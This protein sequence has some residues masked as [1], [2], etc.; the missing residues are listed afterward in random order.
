MFVVSFMIIS[1]L[2][3]CAGHPVDTQSTTEAET[4]GEASTTEAETT[5][6]ISDT[7]ETSQRTV[8]LNTET[9][10]E[11]PYGTEKYVME[12]DEYGR[13]TSSKTYSG[14]AEMSATYF[15]YD[16]KGYCNS[17]KITSSSGTEMRDEWTNDA[18]GNIL[19]GTKKTEWSF[20]ELITSYSYQY[21]NGRV[22]SYIL[23]N[24]SGQTQE[25]RTYQYTDEYGSYIMTVKKQHQPETV[26]TYSYNANK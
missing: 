22:V 25:E 20:R 8:L 21:D 5:D 1:L 11:T 2:C 19:S 23:K 14:T 13:M 18:D 6:E 12:Y 7:D 26:F 10:N 4:T 24:A 15:T 17:E 3:G 16:E 9:T